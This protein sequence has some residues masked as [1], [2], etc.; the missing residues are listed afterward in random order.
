MFHHMRFDDIPAVW[1][2][3]LF[4]D[5]NSKAKERLRQLLERILG[6]IQQRELKQRHAFLRQGAYV[7][8]RNNQRREQLRPVQ[9]RERDVIQPVFRR[10]DR[11]NRAHAEETRIE[12]MKLII[13]QLQVLQVWT[14]QQ[15][16]QSITGHIEPG[17]E[18]VPVEDIDC[19]ETVGGE[20]E[21]ADWN[22]RKKN[23]TGQGV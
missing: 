10:I 14:E 5:S 22:V 15:P 23:C 20:I 21:R 18:I 13:G 8:S 9:D 4:K 17:D 1:K 7:V 12:L 3:G 6:K 2:P 11:G 19:R 16:L